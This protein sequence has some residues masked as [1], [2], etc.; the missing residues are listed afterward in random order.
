MLEEF[1]ISKTRC[2]YTVNSVLLTKYFSGD[3]I[4]RNEIGRACGMFGEVRCIQGFGEKT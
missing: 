4:K 2:I 3:Q 1:Y